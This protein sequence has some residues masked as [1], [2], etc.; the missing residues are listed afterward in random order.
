MSEAGRENGI[1]GRFLDQARED[2]ALTQLAVEQHAVFA[3]DQ[4]RALG[5][6]N[7]TIHKRTAANRLHRI[8]RGVY[9]LVPPALLGRHGRWMAAVLACGPGAVLSHR[10]AAALLGLRASS[11]AL[12]DVTVP[13][14]TNRCHQGLDVHRSTT[15]EAHDTTTAEKIPCTTVARTQLDLAGVINRRGL[16]KAFDQAEILDVFDL[17]A[18][19]DQ[20]ERNAT[21]RASA[22]MRAVMAGHHPGQTVTRH[23]LEERFLALCRSAGIPQPEVNVWLV[24]PDGEPPIQVDFLWR[25][26]RVALETDGFR[27]HR[28]QRSFER[29]RRRDQRLTVAAWRPVRATWRQVIDEPAPLVAVILRLLGP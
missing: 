20:L 29:D 1:Y 13:G 23:E 2:D 10:S 11:R 12:I 25:A 6:T 21:S 16:E 4:A 14:R 18:L 7:T 28:S 5:L 15:L 26:Q 27:F 17:H 9:S 22:R 3:L 19:E 8:H 24:L